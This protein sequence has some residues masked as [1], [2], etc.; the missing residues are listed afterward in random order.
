MVPYEFSFE[1]KNALFVA[2]D[3]A[4]IVPR[5]IEVNAAALA[6]TPLASISLTNTIAVKWEE[7]TRTITIDNAFE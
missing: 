4:V 1:T 6:F 3:I 7:A 2:G 5:E